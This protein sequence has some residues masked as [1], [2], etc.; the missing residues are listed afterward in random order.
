M[1]LQRA[2]YEIEC[3]MRSSAVLSAGVRG[4]DAKRSTQRVRA[5]Q[6]EKAAA[7]IEHQDELEQNL[8]AAAAVVQGCVRGMSDRHLQRDGER[9]FSPRGPRLQEIKARTR[10]VCG[11]IFLVTTQPR[12][13]RTQTSLLARSTAC[14]VDCVARSDSRPLT[15]AP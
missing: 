9:V 10:C 8:Q 15:A 13:L 6:K 3:E 12:L 1:E 7:M 4:W 11:N 5:K 14:T 2:L